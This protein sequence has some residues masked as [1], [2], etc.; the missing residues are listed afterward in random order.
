MVN[1]FM[2]KPHEIMKCQLYHGVYLYYIEKFSK[3]FLYGHQSIKR[4]Y[5]LGHFSWIADKF[6]SGY[7]LLKSISMLGI[8]YICWLVLW[9]LTPLSITFQLY[10]GSQFYWWRKTK[11]P[12]KTTDLPKVTDKLYHIMLYRVHPAWYFYLLDLFS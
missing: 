4:L 9:C 5:L 7:I 3:L 10:C 11:Y 1:S 6:I 8:I 2:Q 12:E